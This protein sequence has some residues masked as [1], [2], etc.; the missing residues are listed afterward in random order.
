[1]GMRLLAPVLLLVSAALPGCAQNHAP[2]VYGMTQQDVWTRLQ[3]A[4]L[5]AFTEARG[6][7]LPLD[8]AVEAHAPQS[9]RWIIRSGGSELASFTVRL[10]AVSPGETRAV[11]DL[12]YD[13]DRT[14]TITTRSGAPA[15]RQPL[16]GAVVELVDA[17]IDDRPYDASRTSDTRNPAAACA[18]RPGAL[19]RAGDT[20]RSGPRQWGAPFGPFAGGSNYGFGI[21]PAGSGRPTLDTTPALG[22]GMEHNLRDLPRPGA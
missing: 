6:C 8:I 22:R 2:G 5:G 14:D 1:M 4:D 18:H 10:D 20:P 21:A 12:P 16:Q 17:A 15:L 11:I 19:H 13:P 9:L 3:S 7:G